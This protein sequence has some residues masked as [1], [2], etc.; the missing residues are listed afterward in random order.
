MTDFD[1]ELGGIGSLQEEFGNRME[2][3]GGGG[4]VYVGT[5]VEYSVFPG[6]RHLKNGRA[7][8]LPASRH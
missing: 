3:W 1:F 5:A 4:T 8:V 2:D 6:V 7:A